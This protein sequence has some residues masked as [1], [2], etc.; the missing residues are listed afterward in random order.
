MAVT[1]AYNESASIHDMDA[2]VEAPEDFRED[3][4]GLTPQ[5]DP[6]ATKADEEKE[7]SEQDEKDE[8]EAETPAPDEADALDPELEAL[9]F[10]ALDP[11]LAKDEAVTKRYLETQRGIAKVLDQAKAGKEEVAKQIETLT[12][13]VKYAQ[14]FED[15]NL[16]SAAYEAL[17]REL[18][19]TARPSVPTDLPGEFEYESDTKV[20]EKAVADAEARALEKFEKLYGADLQALRADREAQA[21][22]KEF[23]SKVEKESKS[24]IGFLARTENG[25]G[26]T[27]E[28]VA[29]AMREMPDVDPA[30]AVK[31]CFPDEYAAHKVAKATGAVTKKGPEM[32]SGSGSASRGKA[33]SDKHPLDASIHEI[34]DAHQS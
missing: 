34:W 3:D 8:S 14:A 24:V 6:P 1:P 27:K 32:P 18:G 11:E 33:M 12:P 22:Q 2:T 21:K 5:P 7:E 17:G 19:I 9:G 31:R 15:D 23:E 13:Y 25:W 29:Q 4:D 10:P 26:V 16:K 30:V 20:Y 28:M